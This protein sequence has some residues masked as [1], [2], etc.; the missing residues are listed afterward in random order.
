MDK[1]A[2]YKDIGGQAVMEGVMMQ[3][4]ADESIAIAVRKPNGKIVVTCKHREPLSKKHKWM[5]WPLEYKRQKR[6]RKFSV[7]RN[8]ACS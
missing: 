5:G 2:N 3:S 7:I 6:N 1:K 8:G 4:P